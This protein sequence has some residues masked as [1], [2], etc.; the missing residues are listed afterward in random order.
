MNATYTKILTKSII[1]AAVIIL[2]LTSQVMGDDCGPT[3]C[4]PS[5]PCRETPVLC[6]KMISSAFC[7]SGFFIITYEV[8]GAALGMQESTCSQTCCCP[9]TN[10][11]ETKTWTENNPCGEPAECVYLYIETVRIPLEICKCPGPFCNPIP[12]KSS[13]I[14]NGHIDPLRTFNFEHT[15]LRNETSAAL[16]M[17][18]WPGSDLDF[19]LHS[20]DGKKI[21]STSSDLS[22]TYGKNET[23]KYYLVQKP[24]IG[25]WMMEVRPIS[26]PPGGENYNIT[27]LTW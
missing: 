10:I 27:I 22:I 24:C 25:I 6:G 1:Y 18:R 9:N 3:T 14:L 20:P 21:D 2:F 23:L 16:F 15:A 7:R 26:V 13:Q 5:G 19:I 12:L 8:Y 17:L 4:S 11:C